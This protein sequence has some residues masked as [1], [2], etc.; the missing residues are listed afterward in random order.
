M[1]NQVPERF[2]FEGEPFIVVFP[3]EVMP[4]IRQLLRVRP[5]ANENPLRNNWC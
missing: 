1:L 3:I 2:Y 5:C 4:H